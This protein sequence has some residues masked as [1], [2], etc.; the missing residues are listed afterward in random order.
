MENI[1]STVQL[2][3]GY[4]AFVAWG[5]GMFFWWQTNN[6]LNAGVSKFVLLNPVS[7]LNTSN[8]TEEGIVSRN[9]ALWSFAVMLVLAVVAYSLRLL[10]E[11][12]I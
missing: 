11:S 10:K 8:F 2:L 9:N 6:R 4:S 5:L 7:Y 3:I 1:I 12:S